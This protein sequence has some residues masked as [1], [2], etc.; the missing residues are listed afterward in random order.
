MSAPG[1]P[2]HG[3]VQSDLLLKHVGVLRETAAELLRVRP[4]AA[5]LAQQKLAVDQIDRGLRVGPQS[6]VAAQVILGGDALAGL[7][8]LPLIDAQHHR[9]QAGGQRADRDQKGIHIGPLALVPQ[10][11]QPLGR[12]FPHRGIV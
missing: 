12:I 8:A 1:L 6:G 11:P 3:A 7:P 10:Q 4:L 9:Q 5:A 2:C